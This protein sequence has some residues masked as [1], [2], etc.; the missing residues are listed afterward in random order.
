M[1]LMFFSK[2]WKF[3]VDSKNAKKMSQKIYSLSDSLIYFG[4]SKFSLLIR[5][6][7]Y[8]G[9]NVLSSSIKISDPIENKFFELSLAQQDQKIG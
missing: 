3:L 7:S 9:V 5:E 4:Y 1:R 8:F 2:L 6:Y